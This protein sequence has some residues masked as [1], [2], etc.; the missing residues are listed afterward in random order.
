MEIE[1][2][3]HSATRIQDTKTEKQVGWRV[4]TPDFTFDAVIQEDETVN[5]Y[6]EWGDDQG[7]DLANHP[8]WGS[9]RSYLEMLLRASSN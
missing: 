8:N 4:E 1:I 3:H 5:T 9:A 7:G 2:L 6:V